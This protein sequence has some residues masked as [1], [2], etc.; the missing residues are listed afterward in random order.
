V[1]RAFILAGVLVVGGI[2][3]QAPSLAQKGSAGLV[4]SGQEQ[5]IEDFG[6]EWR[7]ARKLARACGSSAEY[8]KFLSFSE[9][10]LIVTKAGQQKSLG[11]TVFDDATRYVLGFED[12]FDVTPAACTRNRQGLAP[13]I[14]ALNRSF[15]ANER[16]ELYRPP[17]VPCSEDGLC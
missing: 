2:E 8:M 5:S 6:R 1:I 15:Q 13:I 9:G 11:K 7:R 3:S 4:I 12:G 10:V 17:T 16:L 14:E